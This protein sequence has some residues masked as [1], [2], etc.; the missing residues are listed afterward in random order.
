MLWIFALL[1]VGLTETSR[2]LHVLLIGVKCR[3]QIIALFGKPR[4]Q[5]L[6][7]AHLQHSLFAMQ[8][9]VYERY[10]YNSRKVVASLKHSI[11]QMLTAK[12]LLSYSRTETRFLTVA[13][14]QRRKRCKRPA[15]ISGDISCAVN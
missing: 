7:Q 13:T 2:C 11:L 4:Q 1:S 14:C 15:A 10:D 9:C 8:I 5:A 12:S 6:V 3:G